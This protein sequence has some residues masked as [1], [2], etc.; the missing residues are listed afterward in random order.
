MQLDPMYDQ[1][2]NIDLKYQNMFNIDEWES[3]NKSS[4][5][6]LLSQ[7]VNINE[8]NDITN[9]DDNPFVA[10]MKR[11]YRMNK[12]IYNIIEP[13]Y[14]IHDGFELI[15][16]KNSTANDVKCININGTET[17]LSTSQY[18]IEEGNAIISFLKEFQKN[19]SQYPNIK[20]IG[21]ITGY[22]AQENYLRRNLKSMKIPGIL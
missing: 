5:S 20:S 18:N 3:F 2:K 13:I 21:V 12:G 4:F 1:Y 22:R 7:L 16:G 17:P 19:R 14:S 9:F 10:V 6:Q 11:Q 8:V 15:D